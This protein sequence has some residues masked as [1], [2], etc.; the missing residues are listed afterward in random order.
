MGD[1]T[2]TQMKKSVQF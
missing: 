1:R 2:V